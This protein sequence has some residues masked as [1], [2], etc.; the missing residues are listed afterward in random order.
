ML[1]SELPYEAFGESNT[2]F[3]LCPEVSKC[4]QAFPFLLGIAQVSSQDSLG[5]ALSCV[6]WGPLSMVQ[7]KLAGLSCLENSRLFELKGRKVLELP[8]PHP[9]LYQIQDVFVGHHTQLRYIT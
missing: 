3:C 6:L 2:S 8:F 1:W 4:L 9:T 5:S 7:I